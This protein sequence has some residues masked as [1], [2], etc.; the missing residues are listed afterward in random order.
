MKLRINELEKLASK[1][2]G[3]CQTPNVFFVSKF[4]NETHGI[5]LIT[6]DFEVAY[7]VWKSLPKT[8]ET[9]LEDRK[10]GCIC[11]TEPVSEGSKQLITDDNS[12]MFKKIWAFRKH[13]KSRVGT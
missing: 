11:T 2:V 4:D 5:I 3:D 9:S 12:D 8:C 13:R 6:T 1:M 7:K 10:F